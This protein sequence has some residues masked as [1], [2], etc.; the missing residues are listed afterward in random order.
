[1]VLERIWYKTPPD[2]WS[3]LG[4]VIIIGGAL[5][6]ALAKQVPNTASDQAAEIKAER[7]DSTRLDAEDD[8]HDEDG[9]PSDL[10]TTRGAG[11][12]RLG[13]AR[14]NARGVAVGR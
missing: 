2:A 12:A 4:A 10:A 7:G 13:S 5:R 1:M 3:L 11:R 8:K 6:V 14:A 9:D